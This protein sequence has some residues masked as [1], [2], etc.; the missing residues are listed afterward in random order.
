MIENRLHSRSILTLLL[1]IIPAWIFIASGDPCRQTVN[2]PYQ[3]NE[4][5]LIN[6]DLILATTNDQEYILHLFPGS[7]GLVSEGRDEPE[8]SILCIQG[9]RFRQTNRD[10]LG[11]LPEIRLI[12][13]TGRIHQTLPG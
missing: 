13:L 11:F 4:L 10:R 5:K 6:Q 2:G 1:V 8:F 9:I 3:E 7:Q 12:N